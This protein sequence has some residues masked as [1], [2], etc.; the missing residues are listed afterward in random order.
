MPSKA[1]TD[2]K[3]RQLPPTRTPNLAY[4]YDRRSRSWTGNRSHLA[5]TTSSWPFYPFFWKPKQE[6]ELSISNKM[7]QNA[8]RSYPESN[9]IFLCC[10]F[11]LR[12][13]FIFCFFSYVVIIHLLQRG[14]GV[15]IYCKLIPNWIKSTRTWMSFTAQYRTNFEILLGEVFQ[16]TS[17]SKLGI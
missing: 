10:T 17:N 5:Q 3:G 2:D 15:G 6:S 7:W 14:G 8:F 1:N 16:F 13:Y 9:H 11:Q 12:T 4:C